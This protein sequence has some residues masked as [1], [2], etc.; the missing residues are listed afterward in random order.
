MFGFLKKKVVTRFAPSPTGVLHI[1]GVRTALFNYLYAKKYG[2]KFILRIEDTDKERSKKEY[3]EGIIESFKW[4]GLLHDEMY[5]QSDRGEL[6]KK[7]LEDLIEKGLAFE[8]EENNDKTGKVIRFKNPNKQIT[9]QD[10]IVGEVSFNTEELGD[11]VIARDINSPIYHFV[12]V[13]DDGDMGVTH[14][15][16]GQEHL[17]S[18]A[19]QI[20]ILEALGYDRPVYAHIPLIMSPNGGKLSKRDPGVKS[21]MEY[22]DAGYLKDAI[23]NFLAFIGWNPGDDREIMS[24]KELIKAFS[25]E[26]VQKGGASFNA[27]RLDWVNKQYIQK[28]NQDERVEIAKEFISEETFKKLEEKNITKIIQV[29]T[30]RIENFGELKD[31]EVNGDFDYLFKDPAYEAENLISKKA[32]REETVQHLKHIKEV[33]SELSEFTSK[34]VKDA[35]WD[36]AT[37][38]GRAN[39]L[40]PFRY[41]LSGK[42]RSPDPFDI[43]EIIGKESTLER[44]KKAIGMLE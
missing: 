20:L 41:A 39:V 25:L 18:T 15:I 42:D 40:W 4:L 26:K 2:G 21:V 13:V 5:R 12:V 14:V 28:L 23:L 9:F 19:R 35:L 22:K 8:G 30:E 32:M 38:K 6:Y 16:R 43:A 7:H 17:N 34:K 3:E 44:V 11:F 24:M 37:E 27:K 10:E 33:L 1:G 31:Q 36:Y 29:L